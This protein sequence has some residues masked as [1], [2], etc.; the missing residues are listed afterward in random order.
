MSKHDWQPPHEDRHLE[1]AQDARDAALGVIVSKLSAV[2]AA[3]GRTNPS[4][5]ELA[6]LDAADRAVE[7]AER[8]RSIRNRSG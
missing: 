6:A 5:D 4:A 7:V 2:G 3:I 1:A 8:K